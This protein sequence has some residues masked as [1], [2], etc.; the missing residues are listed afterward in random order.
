M[1]LKAGVNAITIAARVGAV[2]LAALFF[3]GGLYFLVFKHGSIE[4]AAI[5][6]SY[7]LP[8]LFAAFV[9]GW[10]LDKFVE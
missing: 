6:A 4:D 3:L 9:G 2:V 5:I 7:G 1:G 10:I 8:I